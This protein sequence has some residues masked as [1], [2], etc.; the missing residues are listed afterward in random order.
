MKANQNSNNRLSQTLNQYSISSSN[1]S[2]R[3][4]E[5]ASG[6]AKL[7]VPFKLLVMTII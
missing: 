3:V 4:S 5:D 2:A 1:S 6:D 7:C